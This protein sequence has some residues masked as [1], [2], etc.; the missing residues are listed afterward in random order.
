VS[1]WSPLVFAVVALGVAVAIMAPVIGTGIALAVLVALRA[2]STTVRQ[3][4]RRRS[5]DGRRRSDPVVAAALFPLAL[6]RSLLGL[7][8]LAPVALLGASVAVAA[9]IIAVPVHPLP[10]GVALGAGVLVAIVGLGPG[11]GGSRTLLARLFGLVTRSPGQR[12]IAYAGVLALAGWASLTALSSWQTPAYWPVTSLHDQLAH[13]PT[14]R[15]VLTD[16][17]QNLLRLARHLGL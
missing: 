7:L 13:L 8:L 2:A 6:L 17:R 12:A 11:S 14:L 1:A 10:Q 16:V 15:T 9:T 5:D 4:G 3:M